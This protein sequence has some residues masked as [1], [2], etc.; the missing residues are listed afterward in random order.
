V[1]SKSC[2]AAEEEE[3]GAFKVAPM[4]SPECRTHETRSP[5]AIQP[6]K[7][8]SLQENILFQIQYNWE[9]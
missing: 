4:T 9:I 8:N 2:F 5:Q 7:S 6:T 3:A 1:F